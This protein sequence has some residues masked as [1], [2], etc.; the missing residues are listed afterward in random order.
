MDRDQAINLINL[1]DGQYP[2]EFIV[3]YLTYY[4]MTLEEFEAVLDKWANKELFTKEKGRWLP[5]FTVSNSMPKKV[6]VIDYG[7]GN[8]RSVIS[9]FE[10]LGVDS[11][12]ISTADQISAT[13]ALVLRGWCV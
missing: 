9:A 5:K 1:Y 8:I 11:E 6:A 7:A 3:D 13:S 10:Y 2:T 12:V 4:R